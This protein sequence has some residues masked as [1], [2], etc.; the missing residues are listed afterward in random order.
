[1]SS[2]VFQQS[3]EKKKR[4]GVLC[5]SARFAAPANEW[6]SGVVA[7]RLTGNKTVSGK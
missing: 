1:M 4:K 3:A 5:A 6:L 7:D 2:R